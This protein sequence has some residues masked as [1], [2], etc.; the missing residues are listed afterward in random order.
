MTQLI[1][2]FL[3]QVLTKTIEILEI[4]FTQNRLT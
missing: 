4:I 3:V 1:K 2:T